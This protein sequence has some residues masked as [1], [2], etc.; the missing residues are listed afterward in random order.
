MKIFGGKKPQEPVGRRRP[1]RPDTDAP[2]RPN[3]AFSYY[4]QRSDSQVNTGRRDAFDTAPGRSATKPPASA[5]R[6]FVLVAVAVLVLAGGI[7]AL[8]LGTSVKII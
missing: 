6:R 1:L 2:S 5:R 3:S 8:P 4:S 7:Y